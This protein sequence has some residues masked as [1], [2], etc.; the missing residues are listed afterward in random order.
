MSFGMLYICPFWQKEGKLLHLA[1]EN[2]F[3]KFLKNVGFYLSK[4][5]SVVQV[6]LNYLRPNN[7][8]L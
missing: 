7:F 6:E 5:T 2:W 4:I 1:D 3:R 8:I